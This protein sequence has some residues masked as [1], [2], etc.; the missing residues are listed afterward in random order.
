MGIVERK[1]KLQEKEGNKKEGKDKREKSA[2][3]KRELGWGRML[4][5][6][7]AGNAEKAQK[8]KKFIQYNSQLTLVFDLFR[9]IPEKA[10]F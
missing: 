3:L 8:K 2:A 7:K 6:V 5:F 10:S 4:I 1:F 9:P